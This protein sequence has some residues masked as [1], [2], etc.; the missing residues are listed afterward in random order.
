[1]GNIQAQANPPRI[2]LNGSQIQATVKPLR[3]E[4]S[5]YE[6]VQNL[7]DNPDGYNTAIVG[8]RGS[9]QAYMVLIEDNGQANT[10]FRKSDVIE[11]D[12]QVMQTLWVENENYTPWSQSLGMISGSIGGA[13]ALRA[14]SP[15]LGSVVPGPF[16]PFA[17]VASLIGGAIMGGVIGRAIGGAVGP[18]VSTGRTQEIFSNNLSDSI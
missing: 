18:M 12:N 14:A 3:T 5:P 10:E 17:P 8:P 11:I 13:F 7:K 16:K 2:L 9:S 15:L 6:S 4:L 1:M